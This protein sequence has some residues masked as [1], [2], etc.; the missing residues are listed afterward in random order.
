MKKTLTQMHAGEEGRIDFLHGGRGLRNRLYK[1]GFV[2]GQRVRKV[3]DLSW[4]GPVI[5]MVNRSQVAIG[6]GMA[7]KIMIE[8]E[9]KR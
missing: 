4:G 9:K 3:S 1:L 7:G 6:R 8:T 5:V 2:E